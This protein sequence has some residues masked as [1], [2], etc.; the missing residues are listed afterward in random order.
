MNFYGAGL[1]PEIVC[2]I[3]VTKA[4]F[5]QLRDLQ[6]ARSQLG[7][8]RMRRLVDITEDAILQPGISTGDGSQAGDKR[9]RL[10]GS[11]QDSARACLQESQGFRFS[12]P[13]APDD[14]RRNYSRDSES[15][16]PIGN[17]RGPERLVDYNRGG[18]QPPRQLKG[19]LKRGDR[20]CKPEIAAATQQTPNAFN[21]HWLRITDENRFCTELTHIFVLTSPCIYRHY[22]TISLVHLGGEY[23]TKLL[24]VYARWSKM[25]VCLSNFGAG[26]EP[27]FVGF[28]CEAGRESGAADRMVRTSEIR[29]PRPKRASRAPAS[30]FVSTADRVIRAF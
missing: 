9:L 17:R 13:T 30:R 6:F 16:Q 25:F 23:L 24:L 15:M 29:I 8:P 19:S 14:R 12:D 22:G 20:S 26:K 11:T 4:L 3:A 21:R 27:A 1:D 10:R 5:D 28:L 7:A 18:V 2:N